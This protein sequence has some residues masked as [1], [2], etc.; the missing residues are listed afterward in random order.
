MLSRLDIKTKLLAAF[1]IVALGGALVGAIA[2]V[3]TRSLAAQT[4]QLSDHQLPALA[5]LAALDQS[6]AGTRFYTLAGIGATLKGSRRQVEAFQERHQ[7]ARG[8]AEKAF[9]AFDSLPRTPEEEA[10]W[11]RVAPAF[12][13]YLAEDTRIW[14]AISQQNAEGADDIQEKARARFDKELVPPL[15]ELMDLQDP[16]V[17]G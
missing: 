3:A 8:R 14:E 11:T 13:A 6:H 1:T 15:R 17:L 9:A 7:D 16:R 12:R 4:R 5:A 2:L 10:L